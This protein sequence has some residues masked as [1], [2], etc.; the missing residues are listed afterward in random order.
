MTIYDT[1]ANK[2]FVSFDKFTNFKLSSYIKLK[3]YN[4]KFITIL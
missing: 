2:N 3:C 1:I 4:F